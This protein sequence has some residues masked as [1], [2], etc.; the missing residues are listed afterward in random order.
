M[1]HR[2]YKGATAIPN[3]ERKARVRRRIRRCRSKAKQCQ[4]ADGTA[5]VHRDASRVLLACAIRQAS[6]DSLLS[7][8]DR[9]TFGLQRTPSRQQEFRM[10]LA[11][12][13]IISVGVNLFGYTDG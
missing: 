5:G 4:Q 3:E 9:R 10:P 13:C 11:F 7:L 12:P 1:T 2:Q 8:I 6:A